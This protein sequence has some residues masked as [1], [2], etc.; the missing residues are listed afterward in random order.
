[1]DPMEFL[2]STDRFKTS[3]MRAI[4]IAAREHEQKIDLE[5]ARMIRNEIV[6]AFKA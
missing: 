2:T 4:A 3:V 1:M 5:R 6:Q